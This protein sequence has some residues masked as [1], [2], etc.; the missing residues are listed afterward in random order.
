MPPPTPEVSRTL[1][2]VDDE[3]RVLAALKEVLERQGFA[4]CASPDPL[5]AMELIRQ[6]EFGA[7]LSDHLMPAMSGMDLLV[8]CR[9]LQPR[10]TRVLITA[11]LSLPTLVEA[12]NKGEIYRFLAKPWLR[13]ELIAT[14]RNALNRHELLVQNERL[15]LQSSD[16]NQRL[17]AASGALAGK[18]SLLE[19]KSRA[20]D[21]ATREL[22]VRY[23]RSLDLCSRMLATFDPALARQNRTIAALAGQMASA[24]DFLSLEERDVLKAA[25]SLCDIGLISV[26][27]ATLQ[28]LRS[29]PARLSPEEIE[30]LHN[31]PIYSQTLVTHLDD[32][33][34]LAETI[35][36]HH[37]RFDGGGFPDGISGPAIP[38][39]AR[40]LAVAVW[41][42]ESGLT[43]PRAAAALEAEIGRG[44]DPAAV[45]LFLGATRLESIPRPV[46]EVGAADLLPGMVLANGVYSPHG[47]LLFGE[48]QPLNHSTISRIRSH[49]LADPLG[50]RL[51]VYT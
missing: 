16:L 27:R 48:G 37:E 42:T 6:R 7:V 11:A 41:V 21:A 18:E 13:E 45:R 15:L 29:D 43:G 38:R 1:L 4:V 17:S 32:R 26:P 19:E 22:E 3:P 36:A 28:T 5:H 44:L 39:T 50:Q 30:A 9:R 24:A 23:G 2:V 40:C 33:P 20:L 51:L 10:A 34:L 14:V 49:Q 46:R 35:R 47:L 25:G 31:H 12:I 8:E